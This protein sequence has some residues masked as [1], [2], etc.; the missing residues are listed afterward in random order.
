[1][2]RTKLIAAA[3]IAALLLGACGDSPEDKAHDDGK[4]VGEAVRG[5]FDSR[6]IDDAK[7]AATDLQNAVNGVGDEVRKSVRAQLATQR[8]TLAGGVKAL[9][10]GDLAQVKDS[11]Q[12]IRAQA[13]AFSHSSSSVANEFWRGFGQGYDG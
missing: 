11:A 5:L 3:L 7:T 6:S 4:Q 9:Q 10:Q 13:E 1:M 8:D 2:R 12:Q